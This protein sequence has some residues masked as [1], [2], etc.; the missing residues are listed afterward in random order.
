M[1][2]SRKP[3]W[4]SLKLKK[5]L[6]DKG[7]SVKKVI[8]VRKDESSPGIRVSDCLA[9]LFRNSS[10]KAKMIQSPHENRQK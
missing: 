9:G 2:D 1:I 10:Q 3:K 8:T 6:R 4:Y 5:V 7:I